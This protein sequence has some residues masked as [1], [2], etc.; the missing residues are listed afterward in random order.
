M[1]LKLPGESTRELRMNVDGTVPRIDG[2]WL[3]FPSVFKDFGRLL[4]LVVYYEQNRVPHA[5]SNWRNVTVSS[6]QNRKTSLHTTVSSPREFKAW[7]FEKEADEG[8]KPGNA[9]IWNSWT[10]SLQLCGN[11]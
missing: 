3:T 8:R 5:D 1:E 11:C 2:C 7:F 6:S 9:G 4:P 10:R